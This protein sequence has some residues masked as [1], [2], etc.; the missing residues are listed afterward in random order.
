MGHANTPMLEPAVFESNVAALHRTDP[1]LAGRLTST[2]QATGFCPVLTATR[3]GRRN[4]RITR[5]D[6]VVEWFGRTSIPSVRADALLERFEPG[7]ANVL[8]PGIGEGS[9][10]RLL[11]HRLGRHRAVFVWEEDHAPVRLMLQLHDVAAA[12]AEQRLVFL[13]CPAEELTRTLVS[14]LE[15]HPGH[16]C[17]ER[18]MMWP[19][20]SPAE[21]AP[22]RTAVEA[23]Y[24]QIAQERQ[25]ALADIRT[26]HEALPAVDPG[27]PAARPAPLAGP[28][29]ALLA[30]HAQDQSWV[31][32][33]ALAA[34]ASSLGWHPI[35]VDVRG[36][37]DM[38]PLARA[39]RLANSHAGRPD[40]ALL[41][42]IGRHQVHDTLP[43]SVPAVCWLSPQA[44]I[45][46][47]FARQ[48][49]GDPVAVTSN[50]L[51]EQAAA[52]GI[53]E[54]RLTVCPA[55]CLAALDTEAP[56][57]N[58]DRPIDVAIFADLEPVDAASLGLQLPAYAQIWQTA[59]DLLTARIETFT[60][61]QAEA[62]LARAEAKM[63]GRID[64]PILRQE[65]VEALSS[66]VPCCVLARFIA[67]SL[68]NNKINVEIHGTGWP[69]GFGAAIQVPARTIAR[70]GE[71]MSASKMVVHADVT[72]QATGEALLAAGSGAVLVARIHPRD[73][74]AGGLHTLLEPGR[75]ML[76]FCNARE[77]ADQVGGLLQDEPRRRA[78]AD[79]ARCRCQADHTPAAR[80]QQLRAVA[81]SFSPGF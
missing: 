29:I 30:L 3:D 11:T 70:R 18:I 60:D 26:R 33:D 15:D 51:A 19:W 77:L 22:C 66:R 47:D 10:A 28:V 71:I 57:A 16:L 5:P 7:H 4:F 67:Q 64:E 23:A 32:A 27:E 73:D 63:T 40:L 13:V 53:D 78:I 41:L 43:D 34:G 75:E 72:G 56:D 62:L 65:I 61:G 42:D 45:D 6:G 48:A 12:I 21:V 9:E 20:Q 24:Q 54:R 31:L 17:P 25:R 46:A 39:S 50:R 74:Q 44:T 8:L 79:R 14:W 52:C 36:P 81:S 80:L 37:G 35:T 49:A 58:A 59:V 76:V 68:V 1:A 55:P 69:E 38:H 2:G